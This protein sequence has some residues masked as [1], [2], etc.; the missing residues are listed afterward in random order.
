MNDA[1]YVIFVESDDGADEMTSAPLKDEDRAYLLDRVVPTLR[2]VTRHECGTDGDS[3]T[4]CYKKRQ[5]ATTFQDESRAKMT[6]DRSY[7]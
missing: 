2:P 3:P 1:R 5:I 4:R 7:G 6:S